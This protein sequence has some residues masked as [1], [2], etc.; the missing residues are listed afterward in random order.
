[1]DQ[2][3]ELSKHYRGKP[4]CLYSL[5][6]WKMFQGFSVERAGYLRCLSVMVVD[7]LVLL[8][9]EKDIETLRRPKGIVVSASAETPSPDPSSC[10][11]VIFPG[12]WILFM[13]FDILY[14]RFVVLADDTSL[15]KNNPKIASARA[16][17][18]QALNA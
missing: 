8:V 11:Q 7:K 4:S 2:N 5:D 9:L 15:I 16:Q 13:A 6:F 14:G 12:C 1:M 10:D 17:R 3:A 18:I